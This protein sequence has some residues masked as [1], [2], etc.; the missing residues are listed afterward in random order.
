[1]KLG[2]L[3]ARRQQG[4]EHL[5]LPKRV[6]RGAQERRS[7]ERGSGEARLALAT[8]VSPC[9]GDDGRASAHPVIPP[10]TKTGE[11]GVGGNRLDKGYYKD[12][13]LLVIV[14]PLAQVLARQP[15]GT[16][17]S[18]TLF[19]WARCPRQQPS[20]AGSRAQT[21]KPRVAQTAGVTSLPSTSVLRRGWPSSGGPTTKIPSANT[22][23]SLIPGHFSVS[24]IKMSSKGIPSKPVIIVGAGLSGLYAA[25]LSN[26]KNIP[27]LVIEAQ[28]HVG[29]RSFSEET[30]NSHQWRG[31]RSS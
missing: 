23:L 10:G 29:G 11:G 22:F 6:R 17:W 25:K 8:L 31:Y 15:E 16:L 28:G 1:M 13:G 30:R 14:V 19:H 9:K 20:S 12:V 3:E 24:R 4:K 5:G 2:C 27:V 7:Y 26:E 21:E 18:Q